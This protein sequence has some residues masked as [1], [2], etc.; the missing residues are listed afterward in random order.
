[1]SPIAG[2]RA[3]EDTGATA[4]SIIARRVCI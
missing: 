3:G 4:R 2:H 1:M